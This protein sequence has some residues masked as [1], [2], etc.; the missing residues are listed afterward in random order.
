MP[1]ISTI[2]PLPGVS[3][4]QDLSRSLIK[5][6]KDANLE[7]HKRTTLAKRL[8]SSIKLASELENLPELIKQLLEIDRQFQVIEASRSRSRI[9]DAPLKRE[10]WDELNARLDAIMEWTTL[11]LLGQINRSQAVQSN[12]R[13]RGHKIIDSYEITDQVEIP[14]DTWPE[15]MTE[16]FDQPAEPVKTILR[17]G[18]FR[19][20]PVTY[21]TFVTNSEYIADELVKNEME[22]ISRSLHANAAALVGATQ[23][24]NGLDGIV[25]AMNGIDFDNFA[26]RTHSGAVWAKCI[27]GFEL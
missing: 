4:L 22:R 2:V 15:P 13:L 19:N 7:D 23:G 12:T 9:V 25:V 24:Y 11:K 14:R 6:L 21:I 16:R 18:R 8:E 20:F 17:A 3:E 5:R 10:I 26:S 27:R 1:A